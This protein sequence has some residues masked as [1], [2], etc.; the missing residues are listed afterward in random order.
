L[1]ASLSYY[2]YVYFDKNRVPY[3]VGEGT[4]QRFLGSHGRI[5][6]PHQ[7]LVFEQDSKESALAFEAYLIKRI[8]RRPEDAGRDAWK[9]GPLMNRSDGPGCANSREAQRAMIAELGRQNGEQGRILG[10]KNVESGRLARI[11]VSENFAKGANRG[12]HNRWHVERNLT[13][14]NCPLCQ[15]GSVD[16]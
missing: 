3:Y 7:I 8:G 13:S 9:F 2:T 11:F 15:A 5:P 6:L 10:R 1:D 12:R 4:R 16:A 14:P